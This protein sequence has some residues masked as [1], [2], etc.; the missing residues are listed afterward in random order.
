MADAS[1]RISQLR[2]DRNS[3]PPAKRSWLV[4]GIAV[5]AIVIAAGWWLFLRPG[6]SAVVVAIDV[7]RQ[8]P[9][10]AA[11][12]SVLDASGYVVARRQATVSS[13]VTGK[14]VDVFVEEGMRV[15]QDQVVA[16]LD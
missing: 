3:P 7:A 8:P 5:L 16:R 1:E 2:I 9:S 10:V 6:S 11:A 15:E 12:S 14:V 13:K 4:P